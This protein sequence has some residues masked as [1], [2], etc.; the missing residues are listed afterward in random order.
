MS[1]KKPHLMLSPAW[2]LIL[3]MT[4]APDA[5]TTPTAEPVF[6]ERTLEIERLYQRMEPPLLTELMK[7]RQ[8]LGATTVAL[9]AAP[10]KLFFTLWQAT[11]LIELGGFE[12]AVERLQALRERGVDNP[13]VRK[14]LA[15]AWNEWSYDLYTQG[16]QL[17]LALELIDRAITI[18]P[19]NTFL[20]GTKAEVLYRLGLYEEALPLIERALEDYPGHSEMRRDLARI[21]AALRGAN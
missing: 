14:L 6:S 13:L 7:G 15:D 1:Y 12:A 2:T 4:C 3:L 20:L 10:E 17:D 8:C 5:H 19:K 9:K 21:R 18:E 11:C 16:V